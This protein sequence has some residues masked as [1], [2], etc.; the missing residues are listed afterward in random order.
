MNKKAIKEQFIALLAESKNY[1]YQALPKGEYGYPISKPPELTAWVRRVRNAISSTF[2]SDSAVYLMMHKGEQA[3]YAIIGNSL[4]KFNDAK[5]NLVKSIQEALKVLENDIY[6]EV[7]GEE[8]P[9]TNQFHNRKIFIVHGHDH[10]SKNEVEILLKDL[11]L[12][13][14]VLHRKADEGQTIIEKIEKHSN[15]GY[16]VILLT[17]DDVVTHVQEQNGEEHTPEYRSRQNVI[18]EFG[19]F[20]GRLGRNRV[21]CLY[22]EKVALPSDVTGMIYKPFK[23]EI[24]EIK[25]SLLKELKAAGYN[26]SL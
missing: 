21:C 26:I 19:Y 17:P 9:R 7:K 3:S 11:G 22:K 20:I 14:I 24:E 8:H 25:Y 1:T 23:Q 15:V 13:P 12:E 2:K 16:A 6:G 18:F 5:V 4:D 10:K